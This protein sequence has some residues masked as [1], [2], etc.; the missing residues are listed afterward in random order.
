MVLAW[1]MAIDGNFCR[2]FGRCLPPFFEIEN[3]TR[4]LILDLIRREYYEQCGLSMSYFSI[5]EDVGVKWAR[6]D[7]Y[8]GYQIY[9]MHEILYKLGYGPRVWEFYFEEE[10]EGLFYFKVERCNHLETEE[11]KERL[12]ELYLMVENI[13]KA[14]LFLNDLHFGNL[15]IYD[16]RLSILDGGCIS[17]DDCDNVCASVIGIKRQSE[18]ATRKFVNKWKVKYLKLLDD[19][20]RDSCSS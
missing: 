5:D 20:L 3:M 17:S 16:G 6:C 19:E 7:E 10:K 14:G 15:T 9:C 8:T 13:H 12:K 11:I 4:E 18:L 2:A 1:K